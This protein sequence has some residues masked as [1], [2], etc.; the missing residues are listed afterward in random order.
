M[1]KGFLALI[2]A[3]GKGTRFKSEKAKVLFPMLGK[4]MLNLVI[5]CI[6]GLKPEKACVV[7]GHQKDEVVKEASL[8]KVHYVYQKEQ[9]GTAHAVMAARNILLKDRDKDVLIINGDLPLIRSETLKPLLDSHRK[10]GNSL[11]FLTAELE[12][13]TGFGRI[14]RSE[15]NMIKV[16]EE[17]DATPSERKIKEI[18]AGVYLFKIKDLLEA[19]PKVSNQNKKSEY[20]LTDITEIL[21]QEGKKIGAFK[22]SHSEEI[23]GINDRYELAMAIEA[24]RERK[25]RSL[26]QRGVTILDPSTAWIDLDVKIGRDTTIYSSVIIEGDCVVGTQCKLY[27]FVHIIDS[28]VGK[29][30]KVLSSTM[31]EESVIEDDAQVGPFAHLRPKTLL[32]KG[33][34]IGNFVET[35]NTVFGRRSKA[36]HLTY[37][38]DSEV[39]DEVNIGAGTITCNYDGIKK[40]KT[41]IKKGAFIGSGTELV[42]PV[43]VGKRAYV[44]AGSTITKNVSPESL[45]V[46]RSNQVEKPLRIKR[47]KRK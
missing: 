17:K 46:T 21:S 37:L 14:I 2:L 40:H 25:I 10:K 3:A 8:L 5:D 26:A 23:I 43:K 24:L 11:T 12:N 38:G 27:P 41:T 4:S 47:K 36:G 34:K 35:K 33:S 16:I 42:A 18:N 28:R 13:P 6:Q 22:T 45:A 30:V 19:L 20:Y 7:V 31:I 1:K 29:R 9:L 39:E 32:R 44:G 15:H